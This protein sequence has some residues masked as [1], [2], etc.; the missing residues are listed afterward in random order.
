MVNAIQKHTGAPDDRRTDKA[1]APQVTA[2][3]PARANTL[4]LK[5]GAIDEALRGPLDKKD[6]YREEDIVYHAVEIPGFPGH[7]VDVI[8]GHSKARIL[9]IPIK[10]EHWRLEDV[11]TVHRMCSHTSPDGQ[12][13]QTGYLISSGPLDGIWLYW[14]TKYEDPE[15][16][17]EAYFGTQEYVEYVRS[18]PNSLHFRFCD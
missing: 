9:D 6:S 7:L 15:A 3:G 18:K 10:G 11:G 17:N 13:T 5:L 14:Q 16:E 4:G 1:P 12:F 8:A 2:P